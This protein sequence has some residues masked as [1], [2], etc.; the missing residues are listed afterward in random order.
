MPPIIPK[1]DAAINKK[2]GSANI[3]PPG[4]RFSIPRKAVRPAAAKTI[5]PK[6]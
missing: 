3:K 2:H 4:G 5:K 1:I 6:M